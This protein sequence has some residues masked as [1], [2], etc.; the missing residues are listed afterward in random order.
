MTVV[1]E[2]RALL[3]RV[4][5]D[6]RVGRVALVSSFGAESA[7]LLHLV[8]SIDKATPVIVLDTGKLFAATIA[9]RERLVRDLGL[10]DLRVAR[11]DPVTLARRDPNGALWSREPDL[12]CWTRKVEPLDEALSGFDAWITGRK[13]YQAKTR[14]TLPMIEEAE[15]GHRKVNPLAGWNA[16]DIAAYAEDHALPPHPLVPSGYRSI[17]C[18]P[19]TRPT[20]PGEDPRA[21][22]WAGMGKV[23]CGIH[24][25]PAP[26]PANGAD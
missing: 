10:T 9:Y 24:A 20:R 11:P 12:C 4:L 23:E 25:R 8:A 3:R 5:V 26:T 18:E 21:G 6:R 22:R 19:C 7:V 17:G 2:S 14:E 16:A 13:R 15:A 1:E